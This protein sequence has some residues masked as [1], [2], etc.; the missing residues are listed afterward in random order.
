MAEG[1]PARRRW[2]ELADIDRR[3][4]DIEGRQAAVS[5]ERQQ[6]EE[7]RA[8]APAIDSQALAQWH[9][10]GATGERPEPSLPGIE[11]GIARCVADYEALT[12]A[13]DK[14]LTEKVAFVE[15]HRARLVKEAERG[16]EEASARYA[17]LLAEA[18]EARGDALAARETVVWAKL[19]PSEALLRQPQTRLLAGGLQRG[20]AP[21]GLNTQLEAAALYAALKV[22]AEWVAT[23][24]SREQRAALDG[25][26]EHVAR[27]D[28]EAVFV[29]TPEG[30]EA[31]RRERR[32]AL[33][34]HHAMFGTW[35]G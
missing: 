10:D 4:Q 9:H 11:A 25:A 28:R 16:A 29:Q 7:R 27:V 21:L 31:L 13:A 6:L 22:D 26:G 18:E 14:V 17:R 34:Y 24:M 12:L 15:K 8:T 23:A 1:Q 2:P 35:P 3:I 30:Q 20:A 19:F 32:E 5:A 33:E